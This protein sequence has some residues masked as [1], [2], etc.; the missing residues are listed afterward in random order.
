MTQVIIVILV[1][2]CII[3]IAMNFTAICHGFSILF[4][5]ILSMLNGKD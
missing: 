3:T 4:K 2:L 1:I 5:R